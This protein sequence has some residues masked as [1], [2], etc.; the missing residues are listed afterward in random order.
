MTEVM[1]DGCR[2]PGTQRR[3]KKKMTIRISVAP[4]LGDPPHPSPITSGLR[5]LKTLIIFLCPISIGDSGK[6]EKIEMTLS[7]SSNVKES[8]RLK[9]SQASKPS[10]IKEMSYTIVP[11]KPS[12]PAEDADRLNFHFTIAV[13][14]ADVE[15]HII[16]GLA[17]TPAGFL[18]TGDYARAECQ[19][20]DH[21]KVFRT[22]LKGSAAENLEFLGI[23]LP[24]FNPEAW[25]KR[26]AECHEK[27]AAGIIDTFP[28]DE[29]IECRARFEAANKQWEADKAAQRIADLEAQV[30]ALQK[31]VPAPAV[32]KPMGG[33]RQPRP[34]GMSDADWDKLEYKRAMARKHS[35]DAYARKHPKPNAEAVKTAM[36]PV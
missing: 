29:A 28:D 10:D 3:E 30:A 33:K 23:K 4:G 36:V 25:V 2:V 32:K 22:A 31:A 20:N 34:E 19:R 26:A 6:T 8:N 15:Q 1:D 17:D 21:W 7:P 27:V 18:L 5:T 16:A 11:N 24:A 9:E 14:R 12:S 13:S 35:A